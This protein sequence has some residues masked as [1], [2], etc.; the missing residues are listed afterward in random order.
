MRECD[1]SDYP[2]SVF[3]VGITFF[4]F[5]TSTLKPLHEFASNFVYR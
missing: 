3:D 5:S 2:V 1:S 4:T